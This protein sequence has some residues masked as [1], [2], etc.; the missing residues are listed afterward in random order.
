MPT[1]RVNGELQCEVIL[2][3]G[4]R[5]HQLGAGLSLVEQRWLVR[6]INEHLQSLG[7]EVC[8]LTSFMLSLVELYRVCTIVFWRKPLQH[9]PGVVSCSLCSHS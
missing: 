2:K 1:A 4:T 5:R 3:E 7:V 6:R 8:Q 9:G